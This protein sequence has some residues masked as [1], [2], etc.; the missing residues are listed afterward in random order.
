VSATFGFVAPQG[1]VGEKLLSQLVIT[2]RAQELSAPIALRYI[3]LKFEGSL[4]SIRIDCAGEELPEFGRDDG[5][6]Q[7]YNVLLQHSP[8]SS[9]DSSSAIPSV[10]QASQLLAGTSNLTFPPGVT[11]IFSFENIPREPGEIE[12]VSHIMYIEEESFDFEVVATSSDH[13][14]QHDIWI[15]NHAGLLKKKTATKSSLAVKILPRPPR[16]RIDV[17]NLRKSYLADGLVHF[18]I[19]ITNDEDVEAQVVLHAHLLG[20]PDVLPDLKWTLDGETGNDSE[21]STEDENLNQHHERPSSNFL[22]RLNPKAVRKTTLSF[23]AGPEAADYVLRI[24]ALY[25]LPADPDTPIS[26]TFEAELVIERPFEANCVFS[27]RLHPSPWP[28]Y[29]SADGDGSSDT[30]T[31]DA[32]LARGLRQNWF[33]T[34]NIAS[35]AMEAIKIED[36]R[37][38]IVENPSED[39]CT[40]SQP[41][42]GK[43]EETDVI[44]KHIQRR[45]FDLQVQKCSLEDSRSTKL[46][47]QLEIAWR[48]ESEQTDSSVTRIPIPEL[49]IPFGEPRV[50]ALAHVQPGTN[51]PIHL[52]YTI[53]NPS[54][55]VLTFHLSMETSEQFA[56][57]G[58]KTTSI[59]LVPLS[60]H[61]VR[62]TIFSFVQG[63]WITPLFRVVDPYFSK[64][65]K[66]QATHGLRGDSD[67]L[68]IWVDAED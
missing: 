27:P 41:V 42:E 54:M 14:R 15:M 38:T 66:V 55:Y 35:I 45:R 60:R 43:E 37:L 30:A 49:I 5:P 59:Q 32:T 18:A 17:E 51:V 25:H 11:R 19:Q 6:V 58:P 34:A 44:P 56:F 48:H 29:F 47:F 1:I 61:T 63:T 39:I 68:H 16:M 10:R 21:Q 33:L 28:S 67:G 65:L 40:I 24:D 8:A 7:L 46:N 57:S 23:Q 52:D 62:Y 20:H 53:E 3:I 64:T 4:R 9:G 50:L 22:G 13:L 26:K 36:V 31:V 12:I 2:S